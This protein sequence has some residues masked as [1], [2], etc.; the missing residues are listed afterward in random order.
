MEIFY[1]PDIAQGGTRLDTIESGHCIKV[2]RHR[3][4]DIINIVDGAGTLFRCEITDDNP[5]CV[6][7]TVLE[8]QEG[9]GSHP[10]RLHIAVA[11]PKNAERFDWF[12]EKATEMGID[13]ISPIFG[14][15]SERRI[16]KRERSERIMIAAAKQSHKGAIPLLHN[17]VT[18]KDFLESYSCAESGKVFSCPDTEKQLSE[19]TPLRLICYCDEVESLGAV[20]ISITEA[21]Q[22][23]ASDVVVMI[24]PEGDFSREEISLAIKSGWQPV[25]LG[26]SRLRIETAALTAVAAVYLANS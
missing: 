20:K 13:E 21:L 23:G 16:F 9:Y 11:P 19:S 7:F 17:L 14:D 22:K 3:K 4:G 2:L 12:V 26:D 8:R 6:V 10:Y 15:Y 1:S 24:G 5:R 18:V 25:S